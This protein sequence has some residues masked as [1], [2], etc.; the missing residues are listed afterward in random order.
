MVL[1]VF[2]RLNYTD[3]QVLKVEE[4]IIERDVVGI[5]WCLSRTTVLNL[6][7]NSDVHISEMS[8]TPKSSGYTVVFHCLKKYILFTS[9]SLRNSCTSSCV[10]KNNNTS[11]SSKLACTYWSYR[12]TSELWTPASQ[13]V[14][15]KCQYWSIDW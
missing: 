3:F 11:F 5:H 12:W 15:L 2:T 6:L 4:N 8:I 7:G 1:M 9:T 13:T 14:Q 10:L